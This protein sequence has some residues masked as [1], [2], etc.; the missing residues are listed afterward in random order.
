MYLPLPA[1]AHLAREERAEV[2]GAEAEHLYVHLC[3]RN[4]T[5]VFILI[6]II[7]QKKIVVAEWIVCM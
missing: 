3:G 6:V 1:L 2:A 5:C 4:S 7:L